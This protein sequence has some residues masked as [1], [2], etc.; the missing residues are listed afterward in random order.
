ME[1]H[2]ETYFEATRSVENEN[3]SYQKENC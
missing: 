3:Q 2:I 1:K